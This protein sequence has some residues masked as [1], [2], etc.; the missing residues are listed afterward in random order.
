MQILLKLKQEQTSNLW[1]S[2]GGR[3]VKSVMLYEKFIGTMTQINQ[4]LTN[5]ELILRRDEMTLKMKPTAANHPRKFF[6]K[7]IHLVSSLIKENRWLTAEIGANTIDIS[8]GTTDTILPE[9]LKLSTLS[10]WWLPTLFHPD[11]LQTKAETSIEILNKWDQDPEAFLR[12][13][14][15]NMALPVWS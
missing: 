15:L 5:G 3:M 10:I 4:Q 7:K 8:I 9:N 13:T 12:R 11:Q 2:L 6:K 14:V 1:W